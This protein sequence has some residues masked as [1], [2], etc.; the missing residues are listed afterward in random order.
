MDQQ[1]DATLISRGPI[2]GFQSEP[3]GPPEKRLQYVTREVRSRRFASLVHPFYNFRAELD[4]LMLRPQTPGGLFAGGGDID[5]RLKTLFDA[6]S[7][8]QQDQVPVGW[9][10]S[11]EQDPLYCLLDDDKWI[12]RVS[13]RTDR[14]LAP[15]DRNHVRLTIH[16][17]I[18]TA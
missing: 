6:M 8:P 17:K 13:V 2:T 11:A 5:N 16:V 3:L 14:L 7:V 18:Q 1:P 10:P 12:S 15:K 4:V 9:T